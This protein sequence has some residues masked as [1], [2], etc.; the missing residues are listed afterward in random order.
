MK[1]KYPNISSGYAGIPQDKQTLNARFYARLELHDKNQQLDQ[2]FQLPQRIPRIGIFEE[3]LYLETLD[4][5]QAFQMRLQLIREQM[6]NS[7]D[8]TLARKSKTAVRRF[9]N[10]SNLALR[11]GDTQLVL[12]H[13]SLIPTDHART[14]E[15]E[16]LKEDALISMQLSSGKPISTNNL[17]L[18][19]E[20]YASSCAISD[21]EKIILLNRLIVASYRHEKERDKKVFHAHAV[22]LLRLLEKHE[23]GDFINKLH[24]S[25][26]YRGIAMVSEF[27]E[28][29]QFQ[30]L[31]RAEEIALA[32][33]GANDNENTLAL[34]NLYTCLQS[35]TKWHLRNKD[36][37]NAE[38]YFKKMIAID[39][40]DSTGYSEL[41][42]HY[43]Q[44]ENY[45]LAANYLQ[46]AM[47][48]GP[49]GTAMN[50]YYYAKCLELTGEIKES[51]H[52]LIETTTLD[53]SA[54]SPWI[55]LFEIYK[56][57]NEI[58]EAKKCAMHI[59]STEILR[60]QLENDETHSL[61]SY[62][63]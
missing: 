31:K 27:N 28:D 38:T 60:T 13:A 6:K 50:A 29:Q 61:Q 17:L 2:I 30:M 45:S 19:A 54:L 59:L 12:D 48:L 22:T 18:L 7:I 25:I 10:I 47:K 62:I 46:T 35:V 63:N 55:D 9:I 58:T 4:Y 11:Y 37:G 5:K 32:L 1:F 39:P 43:V 14:L 36:H 33:Q 41:G 40:F 15:V 34:E 8:S 16:I 49:P 3:L 21:R 44:L 52:Y 26:G 23:N 53:E 57:N 51:I 42:L 24:C 56:N 20:K